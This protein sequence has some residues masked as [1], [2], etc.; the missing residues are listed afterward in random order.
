MASPI[1]TNASAVRRRWREVQCR[2]H[3]VPSICIARSMRFR[4]ETSTA[5]IR[6]IQDR[7]RR[8][9][10]SSMATAFRLDANRSRHQVIRKEGLLTWFPIASSNPPTTLM[11]LDSRGG[12][13]PSVESDAC[14]CRKSGRQRRHY[15]QA[16]IAHRKEAGD[17]REA[18]TFA[19][20]LFGG[21]FADAGPGSL[22]NVPFR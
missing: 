9:S 4:L 10:F 7:V 20:S 6:S 15:G 1:G 14:G 12:R 18:L 16:P 19:G 13:T 21:V 8:G 11:P 2:V 17:V 22:H 3:S 5:T